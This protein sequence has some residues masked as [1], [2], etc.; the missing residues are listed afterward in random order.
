MSPSKSLLDEAKVTYLQTLGTASSFVAWGSTVTRLVTATPAV[1]VARISTAPLG[2]EA[3]KLLTT[4]PATTNTGPLAAGSTGTSAHASTE[5]AV[6]SSERS[7]V[8][9]E[10]SFDGPTP[11]SASEI[12]HN[13]AEHDCRKLLET[14]FAKVAEVA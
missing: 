6:F 7:T 14:H 10:T 13:Q 12:I 2:S 8:G 11:V 1:S 3:T 9:K 5:K 4:K